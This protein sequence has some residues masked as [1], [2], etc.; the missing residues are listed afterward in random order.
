[1]TPVLWKKLSITKLP[2]PLT[3][4]LFHKPHGREDLLEHVQYIERLVV[5][6][7]RPWREVEAAT[8]M[9]IT[10]LQLLHQQ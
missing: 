3:V 10:Q 5:V 9:P 1:M 8:A 6:R 4:I 7:H 2:V